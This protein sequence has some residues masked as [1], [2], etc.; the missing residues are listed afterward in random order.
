[1]RPNPPV[2]LALSRCPSSPCTVVLPPLQLQLVLQLALHSGFLPRLQLQ[3]VL[4]MDC[5]VSVSVSSDQA[6]YRMP[7]PMQ[8][9]SHLRSQQ[10]EQCTL[11]AATK[12][13]SQTQE[14]LLAQGL[15]PK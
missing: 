2:T 14:D 5:Q 12:P 3:L 1:M 6:L 10:A 11:Q 4:A 8:C 13:L 15:P 9:P 7:P